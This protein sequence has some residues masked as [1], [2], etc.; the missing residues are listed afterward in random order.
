MKEPSNHKQVH[1]NACA[2]CSA[3]ASGAVVFHGA[4]ARF[5]GL[6]R[7]LAQP[8]AKKERLTFVS[9]DH[10]LP[11]EAMMVGSDYENCKDGHGLELVIFELLVSSRRLIKSEKS[12]K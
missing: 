6:V 10:I 5:A 7:A 11:L 8:K 3:H 1:R 9:E 2:K 12:E 4:V